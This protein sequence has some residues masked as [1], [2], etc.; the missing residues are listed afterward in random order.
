MIVHQE[1][2]FLQISVHTSMDDDQ[3]NAV[4]ERIRARQMQLSASTIETIEETKENVVEDVKPSITAAPR[5]FGSPSKVNIIQ[6]AKP[7]E[8]SPIKSITPKAEQT[9]ARKARFSALAAELDDFEVDFQNQYNKPKEAYMKGRSPRMSIGETRTSVLCTPAGNAAMRSPNVAGGATKSATNIKIEPQ[10]SPRSV[11]VARE[12]TKTIKFAHPIVNVNYL[13]NESSLLSGRSS[14]NDSVSTVLG[15]SAEMMNVTTSSLSTTTNDLSINHHITVENTLINAQSCEN[16]DAIIRERT[17]ALNDMTNEEYGAHTFM[18][19]KPTPPIQQE[20]EDANT[21]T[22]QSIHVLVSSPKPFSKYVGNTKFS[23]VHFTPQSTSSPLPKSSKSEPCAVLSPA[24]TAALENACARVRRQELEER[25]RGEKNKSPGFSTRQPIVNTPHV[26]LTPHQKN[27]F[28]KQ[29]EEEKK[30]SLATSA[31]KLP[32]GVQTQWRGQHNT[33]VVQGARADEKTAGADVFGA[34]ASK[35]KN[36]KSRWE[37]SSATGTPIHPDASEDSLIA[38][39]IKMKETAIPQKVGASRNLGKNMSIGAGSTASI[40]KQFVAEEED[41]LNQNEEEPFIDDVSEDEIAETDASRI[42]DQ[43]FDFMDRGSKMGG[44][45]PSPYRPP[46]PLAQFD[47]SPLKQQKI[48]VIEEEESVPMGENEEEEEEIVAAGDN[49]TKRQQHIEVIEESWSERKNDTDSRLPYTVSFYRKIQKEH[50]AKSDFTPIQPSAPP[51]SSNA[52][53]FGSPK[54]LR[55]LTDESIAVGMA[56][57]IVETENQAKE[58][59]KKAIKIEDEHISQAK[60]AIGMCRQTPRF[61]G[62]REEVELQ[63]AL[64]VAIERQRALLAEFERLKRDGPII[65]DGP[66]GRID[67][68]TLE[69]TISREFLQQC[70]TAVMKPADLYYF[71]AVLKCGEQVEVT[72]LQTSDDAINK[73]G[74]LEFASSLKLSELPSDFKAVVEFYGQKCQR[75]SITHEAKFNLGKGTLKTKT[76][77]NATLPSSSYYSSD[78]SFRLLGSF[79]FDASSIDKNEY[80]LSHAIFPLD[81]RARMK[82]VSK[83]AIEGSD[84]EYRGFLSM[85]QRTKEGLGSWTRYWCVLSEGQM[86][87]WRHPEDERSKSLLVSIDLATCI[88]RDGASTVNEVC[89]YPN[90]FHIGVWVSKEAYANETITSVNQIEKLRVMLAADTPSDLQKWLSAINCCSR[91]LYVWRY[92]LF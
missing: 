72:Q 36:L 48:D 46:A 56:G 6:A 66:R 52:Q 42:I 33:P 58:R 38:T 61:R 81:G 73:N 22:K 21:P 51:C 7:K 50:N 78:T 86:K 91:Q 17:M 55:G 31:S 79:E 8:E 14:V 30:S 54:M 74:S 20:V 53:N 60:R 27:L 43:A 40:G 25:I 87:F 11:E 15:G 67:I 71:V 57:R 9:S 23:P 35:L 88:G 75:E 32:G 63:R 44:A 65:Y 49:A 64:L 3:V 59:I 92:P 13:P 41:F 29:E 76:D 18:R 80:Q 1:Q 19:K 84:V 70:L 90:S 83:R 89:P 37:F 85:Y 24:K 34:G 69:V 68:G 28:M 45:T 39:A 10:S 26:H 77:K 4:M 2:E 62:S 5:T 12:E 47:E 82:R 16:R